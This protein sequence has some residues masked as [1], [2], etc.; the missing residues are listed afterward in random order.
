MKIW[1]NWKR[2]LEND[3][4]TSYSGKDVNRDMMGD[5]RPTRGDP[6]GR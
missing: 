3:M 5:T 1:R 6:N 4:E 2:K